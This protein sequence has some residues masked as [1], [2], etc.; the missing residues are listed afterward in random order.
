M[1]F[2]AKL[3][4]PTP[5]EAVL[6]YDRGV[7]LRVA[8]FD[9]V[10]LT[11]NQMDDFRGDKPGSE[12]VDAVLDTFGLFL[13]DSD[14]PYDNQALEALKRMLNILSTRY[15]DADQRLRASHS[16]QGISTNE[17]AHTETMAQLGY[18]TVGEKIEVLKTQIKEYE[19]VAGPSERNVRPKLDPK[20]TVFV[21]NPPREFP[22]VAAME[23]FLRENA[24]IAL[25]HKTFVARQDAA[26]PVVHHA[27]VDL[28][29]PT[30]PAEVV[31]IGGGAMVVE[32]PLLDEPV[33]AQLPSFSTAA[34]Q[35]AVKESNKDSQ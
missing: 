33:E 25:Q 27:P 3:M 12:A 23:F 20:R 8:G 16:A 34:T 11:M 22:S 21:L 35:Q 26:A 6:D 30:P 17:E 29:V 13:F 10:P 2:A 4:N 15:R 14:R 24:E 5:W 9:S 1:A 19:R 32:T 28:A 31:S 18:K 7:R